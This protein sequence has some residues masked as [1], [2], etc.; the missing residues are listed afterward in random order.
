M[1]KHQQEYPDLATYLL[2]SSTYTLENQSIY[3]KE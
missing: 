1:K 2:H 3:E